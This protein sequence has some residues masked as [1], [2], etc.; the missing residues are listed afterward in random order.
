MIERERVKGPLLFQND[1]ITRF[2]NGGK[3]L[4]SWRRMEEVEDSHQCEELLVTSIGAVSKGES[5]GFAVSRT[6]EEQGSHLLSDIIKKYPAEV[7]GK[8]FEEYNP[9]NLSVLARVGD[10]TVR[11]VMQCHLKCEDARRYFGMNVGKTEAWYMADVRE[12]GAEEPCVYAGFKENVT[13]ELWRELF[14]RQDTEA[15]LACM[16][17]IPVRRGQ[18]ILIPAGM[19]HCVGPNCLFVEFHECN[20]IT[21]RLERHINGM[22]ISDEEMFNGLSTDEGMDLFDYTVYTEEQIRKKICMEERKAEEGTEYRLSHL[23]QQSDNDTF[24][25]DLLCLNGSYQF[26]DTNEHRVLVAVQ[27]DAELAVNGETWKLIQGHGALIPAMCKG[28]KIQGDGCKIA[29]GIPYI[30]D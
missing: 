15:M 6:I 2:Y 9:G 3:L 27:G 10:T 18:T 29:I 19:V 26:P 30:P 14:E 12:E 17:R 28:L 1:R 22:D 24:G 20:D 7:L 23:I 4:N 11:L 25:I 21:I 16:H 8:E 13:K 5:P